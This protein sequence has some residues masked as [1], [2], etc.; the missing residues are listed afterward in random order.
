VATRPQ[1]DPER[2][3]V[4]V[5][6][7]HS[8]LNPTRVGSVERPRDSADVVDLVRRARR[9]GRPLCVAGGRHAM[10]GQQFR[11]GARL[12]DARSLAGVRS[13]DVERGL[14]VVEAG[15]QWRE[16]VDELRRR[17]RGLG[18]AWTIRQKQTGADRLT[19]GGA[20][21]ANAHGR[22]LRLP[23]LVG[24]VESL[25]VVT[26]A[27]ELVTARRD[28]HAD[29]FRLVVGGYGLFGIV[30]A[31][32]LRLT[33]RQ[34]LERV[35]RLA[36]APELPGLFERRLEEGFVH[37]DFQFAIDPSSPDFLRLGVF[38]CH[39]PVDPRA[40]SVA[41]AARLGEGDWLELLRLAHVDK[42]RAFERYARHYL[43][44][45][46]SLHWSDDAQLATYVDGYHER[47]GL[48]GSE[49]ISEAHVA[50][51]ALPG[52]LAAAARRLREHRADPIYGTVRLVE[53]DEETALPWARGR[54]AGV[55]V[56][57]HVGSAEAERRR[58][59]AAFRALADEAIA[60]GGGFY[61][62]YHRWAG[63][64]QLLAAHPSLPEVLAESRRRD[65]HGVLESDWR[66]AIER[67]L[68]AGPR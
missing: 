23:P 47:L 28:E 51:S 8:G 52:F 2:S 31:V 56:N 50:R 67:R 27:G 33:P 5:N 41:P 22:C 64:R 32:S 39:R 6:D 13:L 58:A 1:P 30:T 55:V 59:A 68:Q 29:L 54:W 20:V 36:E 46:G 12:V 57:L 60:R 38:A 3:G 7:V 25:E 11:A 62:T 66:L 37:G 44:T 17:Q 65:P 9:E 19:L 4:L 40:R 49:V 45:D 26:P 35:V 18:T 16:L 43:S 10:G 42:S 61:L 21:A 14:A 15:T 53:Q 48:R 34:R 63:R 24:D